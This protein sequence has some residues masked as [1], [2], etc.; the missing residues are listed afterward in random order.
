MLGVGVD[1]TH[2]KNTEQS[3]RE[4]EEKYLL[5]LNSTAEAIYGLDLPGNCT[6]CN[7]SCL[8][9]L[10]YEA[11]ASWVSRN[12][13]ALIHHTRRDGTPYPEEECQIYRAVREGKAS[14]VAEEVLWRGDGTSFL[15]E[16]RSYPMYK[17]GK[18]L[19][20]RADVEC[21]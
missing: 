21:L 20:T 16:Y 12:M 1:I 9:L 3:L 6:F 11:P 5:L 13:H 14:H 10:G 7:P 18:L 15:A 2:L 19:V 17:S 4:S 8:R